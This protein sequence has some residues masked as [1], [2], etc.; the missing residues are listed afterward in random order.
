MS[1]LK[2]GEVKLKNAAECFGFI[3]SILLLPLVIAA[4]HK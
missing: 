2:P 1:D 3:L 4:V